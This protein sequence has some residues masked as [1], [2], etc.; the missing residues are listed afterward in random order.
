MENTNSDDI[1]TIPANCEMDNLSTNIEN[2]L[3][4]K[5][6][7]NTNEPILYESDSIVKISQQPE[8]EISLKPSTLKNDTK[9]KNRN[10]TRRRQTFDSMDLNQIITK[11]NGNDLR[12]KIFQSIN[13]NKQQVVIDYHMLAF[14][15]NIELENDTVMQEHMK[16]FIEKFQNNYKGVQHIEYKI[17]N[18]LY[19]VIDFVYFL[20]IL[21]KHCDSHQTLQNIAKR[22]DDINSQ[23]GKRKA[24][25]SNTQPAEKKKR[26]KLHKERQVESKISMSFSSSDEDLATGDIKTKS[27]KKDFV[28]PTVEVSGNKDIRL[29]YLGN[30]DFYLMCRKKQHFVDGQK[31]LEKKY[32]KCKLLKTWNNYTNIKDIV[33]IVIK[34]Y[35]QLKWN[36]RTNILSNSKTTKVTENELVNYISKFLK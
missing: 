26:I 10:I 25:F 17:D 18:K 1:T 23:L 8:I 14:I 28:A 11:S 29:Y 36:A 13:M 24:D 30:N 9:N 31:N 16:K 3:D 21:L 27:S 6:E 7:N 33:K 4:D 2:D 19:C 12:S 34:N 5:L 15:E 32:G 35:P 20:P 22:L